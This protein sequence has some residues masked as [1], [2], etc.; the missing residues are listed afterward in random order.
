MDNFD[1]GEIMKKAKARKLVGK[2]SISKVLYKKALAEY[3]V[4]RAEKKSVMSSEKA[5]T[6]G[7]FG[8]GLRGDS[9]ASPGKALGACGFDGFCPQC[10]ARTSGM[11]S[12]C[13]RALGVRL[14][15]QAPV[16][17]N[18]VINLG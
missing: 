14:P 9:V 11:G 18:V 1:I 8:D 15:A 2:P 10:R 5:V 4:P 13:D 3:E 6:M 16:L 17:R 7:S 12:R